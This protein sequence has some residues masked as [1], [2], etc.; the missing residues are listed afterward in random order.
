MI[1]A[2]SYWSMT[3]G[4]AGTHPIADALATAKEHGYAGLELAIS[5]EGVL[6]VES[7]QTDCEAIRGRIDASGVAVESAACG[8]GW[9]ASA[10]SDDADVRKQAIDWHAASLQ[11]TA[12]IGAKISDESAH[13]SS[14]TDARIEAESRQLS[15]SGLF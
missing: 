7:S 3:D 4:L 13:V 12:W 11:R 6:T 1:K 14:H 10:T 2:I 8:L 5:N 9:A 15:Q